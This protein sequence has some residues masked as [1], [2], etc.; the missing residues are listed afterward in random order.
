M[1]EDKRCDF[2]I[3]GGKV[4]LDEPPYWVDA[5]VAV[6]GKTIE[7]LIDSK[8]RNV[9]Q[10]KSDTEPHNAIDKAKIKK[11]YV[12]DFEYSAAGHMVLPGLVDFHTHVYWGGTPLGV[13]PDKL[14]PLTGVTTWVDMGSSGAGNFEGLYYHVL[15]RSELSIFCFL[16]LSFIGLTPVGDT[17]LRFGELFDSRLAD[18]AEAARI[19]KAFPDVIKGIKIRIGME[20]ALTEGLAYLDMALALAEKLELPL[21]VHATS[22]PPSTAEVLSRL[23]RDD[24]YTHCFSASSTSGIIDKKGII[25]PEAQEAKKRGVRFDL[26]Y[27]ARSFDSATAKAA[28]AQGFI[29]DFI[30]SDLHAYSLASTISGLPAAISSLCRTGLSLEEALLGATSRPADYLGLGN[31]KSLYGDKTLPGK[32]GRLQAG[33]PADICL[34]SWS[35]DEIEHMDG[36][37]RLVRGPSLE[38]GTVFC[39]GKRLESFDDG[40]QEARWKPGLVAR[41]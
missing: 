27:G 16:H 10:S 29:P 33:S 12:A 31:Y 26:G 17:K 5:D 20:S 13:N 15:K 3:R 35:K 22:A 11:A 41:K 2:I 9:I 4:F 8:T 23:R 32:A 40:R 24:I 7:A 21:V 1:S 19:C 36:A 37:G 6:R 14:A 28:I 34:L 39:R 30:S 18:T 38:V 25:I